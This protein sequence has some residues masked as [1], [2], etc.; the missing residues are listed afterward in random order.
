[1][2]ISHGE[3]PAFDELY[4]RYADKLYGYIL[5]MLWYNEVRAQDLLQDLFTKIIRQ[6]QLFDTSKNFKTWIYTIASNLCKNEFKRNEVRKNTHNGLDHRY[7][8]ASEDNLDNTINDL[9][10]M[11][12]LQREL[13]KL[14][15]KHREV[16]VL[17]H[18]D[19]LSIKEIAEIMS[20]NEG[21][22]KSRL[23]YAI[24]KLAE[25]LKMFELV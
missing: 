25:E 14:D 12:A 16:F 1:M 7:N 9:E 13:T 17:K 6:P 15:E 10:F 19:G 18:I 2:A 11:E 22:V 5:K 21:T 23:F 4:H 8:I 20:I 24:K 3:K